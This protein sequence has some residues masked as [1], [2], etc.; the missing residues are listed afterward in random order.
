MTLDFC[1]SCFTQP[2]YCLL[3]ALW[4]TGR[5]VCATHFRF[6]NKGTFHFYTR[7][8]KPS[9]H[10]K[11]SS[12]LRGGRAPQGLKMLIP[13]CPFFS[14]KII[15]QV[16]WKESVCSLFS[17]VFTDHGRKAW[18]IFPIRS[19]H[20]SPLGSRRSWEQFKFSFNSAQLISQ[21]CGEHAYHDIG[22][23]SVRTIKNVLNRLHDNFW[24]CI[25]D[26]YG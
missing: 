24:N 3:Q 12:H 17:K 25:H 10:V 18:A 8:L 15:L 6:N 11:Q 26:H 21:P 23:K 1:N 19:H 22:T 4:S 20:Y 16:P 5:H 9:L 2:G 13:A 7:H 14:W